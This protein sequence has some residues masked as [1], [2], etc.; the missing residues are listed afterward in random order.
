MSKR[1]MTAAGIVLF[2]PDFQ[3]VKSNLNCLLDQ[4]D[5]IYLVDNS[6]KD[7]SNYFGILNS[8]VHYIANCKNAGIAHAL[9]Q[10]MSSA[11][12]DGCS[13]V[14]T[15]DQDSKIENN[16]IKRLFESAPSDTSI[17]IISP[18]YFDRYRQ[19]VVGKD[20]Y[21][22]EC[23]TSGSL[24]RVAAWK[25]V[26]GFEDWL[27]IDSVDFAFCADLREAGWKIFQTT[28]V[29]MSHAVGHNRSVKLFG[30]VFENSNHP[31]F[32]KYYMTRN[33]LYMK[34]RENDFSISESIV[35]AAVAIGKILLWEPDKMNKTRAIIRGTKDGIKIVFDLCRQND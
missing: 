26:E 22:K 23:I 4:V 18:S 33:R 2:N 15:F 24:T 21:V 3:F 17:G 6:E 1:E 14:V 35:H 27:F 19:A 7:N 16:F 9:N 20:G 32:R 31:A 28:K 10:I 8:N 29:I 13:W 25:A 12:T 30:H 11:M 34:Y 5:S